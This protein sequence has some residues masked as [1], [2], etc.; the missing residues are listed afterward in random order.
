MQQMS[1]GFGHF[2]ITSSG[3]YLV[4]FGEFDSLLLRAVPA[5]GGNVKHSIPELNKC[6]PAGRIRELNW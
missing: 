3:F 4:D 5:N 2:C 1:F 6:P